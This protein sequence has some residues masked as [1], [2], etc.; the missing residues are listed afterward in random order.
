[1]FGAPDCALDDEMVT[2]RPQPA[3]SMSGTAACTQV[4]VPV[5]L[6][7]MIRSHVSGGDVERPASNDSMPAL[8]TRISTGPS[9][10]RT[11]ANP[12]STDAA[13]GD[14]DLD[15]RAPSRRR[16]SSRGRRLG[17][18]AVAVE[19]GDAVAVGGE[20]AG[21]AEAD[22]RGAAGDDG[23]AAHAAASDGLEL[24]VQLG[25]AAED[26]RRLVAEAAVAGRAVVLLGQA[27]VAHAVEDALEADPAL[28]PGQRAAG[29]GVDAAPERDVGLGVGPVD[30][31]LVRGT[32][33]AGGRGWRRR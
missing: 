19:E 3:A 24:E 22:A 4:N 12:A 30:A 27:D 21:D 9:S 15:G 6:T 5:R 28:G 26:P 17:R 8:V 20:L 31:E 16:R 32:R 1:M 11:S 33:T 14:V 13:V 18:R 7:A 2:M 29:A 25:E 23:D 10:A